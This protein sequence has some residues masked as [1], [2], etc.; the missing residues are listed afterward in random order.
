MVDA[1]KFTAIATFAALSATA[2]A[3]CQ[4]APFISPGMS[5]TRGPDAPG[6]SGMFWRTIALTDGAVVQL[7][8][9]RPQGQGPFP[10][11]ILLHGTHGFS[12]EYL[13]LAADL[14]NA[15]FLAIAPCWFAPGNGAGM[16]SITPIP[17]PAGTPGLTPNLSP[18]SMQTLRAIM[19]AVRGLPDVRP[20]QVSLFGHSRGAGLA[21]NYLIETGDADAVILNSS[22]YPENFA[23]SAGRIASPVLML[24]GEADDAADGGS[25]MTAVDM[26]RSF[27][28]AMRQAGKSLEAHYYPSGRHTGIF[29]DPAQRKDEMERIVAFLRKHFR[30]PD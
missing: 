22:G 24:H 20:G 6:A 8:I 9:A 19:R 17:C 18:E 21:L 11:V 10:T 16:S 25:P 23:A 14:S 30:L 3:G 2:L 26:A 5:V 15:G 12:Q 27:E 7:A 4:N 13:G 1:R 29:T 28:V